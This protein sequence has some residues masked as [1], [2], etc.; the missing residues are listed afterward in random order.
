MIFYIEKGRGN[1]ISRQTN[2]S[3]CSEDYRT[4]NLGMLSVGILLHGKRLPYEFDTHHA[5]CVFYL[6]VGKVSSIS[7]HFTSLYGAYSITHALYA[8]VLFIYLP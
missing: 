4:S 3:I 2:L 8:I 5:M 7:Y 1:G 6:N